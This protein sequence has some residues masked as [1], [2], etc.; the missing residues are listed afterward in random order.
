MLGKTVKNLKT[1]SEVW[2]EKVKE[3]KHE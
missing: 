1:F 2:W 3:R